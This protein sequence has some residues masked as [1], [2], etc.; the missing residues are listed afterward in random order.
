M[1]DLPKGNIRTQEDALRIIRSAVSQ[2]RVS[3]PE[4]EAEQIAR[5]YDIP[6][7]QGIL[8]ETVTQAQQIARKLRFPL[9]MKISSP[10]IL[11]KS[12]VGG[13]EVDIDSYTKVRESFIKLVRSTRKN[14]R[15]ARIASVYIQKMVPNSFEFMVGGLRDPQFGPT[16][17]FGLG[18][19]Y[20]E[21]FKDVSFSLA[22]LTLSE[23]VSMMKEIKSAPLLTGY[24]GQKP[25]DI[26][27]ASNVILAVGRMLTE[28]KEIESIDINPL[29][30]YQKGCMA[31]DV[32][33]ILIKS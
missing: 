30:I 28:I 31:V 25:L 20:V 13:V 4:N 26:D 22:P 9:V 7:A 27:S 32:R 16:V 33:I 11:H 24:R 12:D 2:N 15:S 14:D 23:A 3:L 6:V 8:A 1:V 19:V 18:G 5:L 10:D 21:L 17:M 29:F